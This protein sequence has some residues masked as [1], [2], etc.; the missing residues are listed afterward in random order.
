MHRAP[1]LLPFNIR[2]A[3]AV[4]SS[5]T[6]LIQ[7]CRQ[8]SFTTFA[9]CL[10]ADLWKNYNAVLGSVESPDANMN[11]PPNVANKMVLSLLRD[12][13]NFLQHSTR[14]G[15]FEESCLCSF[16][17]TLSFYISG[18]NCVWSV[19]GVWTIIVDIKQLFWKQDV[20]D[21]IQFSTWI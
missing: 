5:R 8:N 21:I 7:N 16:L 13:L 10:D 2:Y 3:V 12:D 17:P 20:F 4:F 15:S 14:T 9:G 18:C 19:L 6:N 11:N 1:F